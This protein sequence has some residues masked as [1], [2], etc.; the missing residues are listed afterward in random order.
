METYRIDHLC[1]FIYTF[2]LFLCKGDFYYEE[3]C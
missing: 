1:V 2:L 3:R